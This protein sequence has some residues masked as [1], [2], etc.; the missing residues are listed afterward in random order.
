MDQ[1]IIKTLLIVAFLLFAFVL[2][3]S[4]GSARRQ[5]IRSLTL[6]VFLVA[7]IITVLFPRIINDLA[8][9]VGIGRGADLLLYAFI[10]VFLGS[11]LATTRKRR[12]QDR[13][14]TQLARAL[15]LQNPQRPTSA[16]SGRSDEAR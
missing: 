10:V 8:I 2:I 14:I 6:L 4:D 5:A 12:E 7:A 13:Q 16:S 9:N 15:A 3:R 1:I 11:S